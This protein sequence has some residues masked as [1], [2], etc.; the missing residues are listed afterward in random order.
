MIIERLK[1]VTSDSL[2]N[3]KNN[4]MDIEIKPHEILLNKLENNKNKSSKLQLSSHTISE[5]LTKSTV[6]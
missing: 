6:R 5:L 1:G 3:L 4:K 2:W